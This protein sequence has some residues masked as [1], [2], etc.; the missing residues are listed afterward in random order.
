MKDFIFVTGAVEWEKLPCATDCLHTIKQ[1]V[2][3][4]NMKSH[5]KICFTLGFCKWI[6][7][8]FSALDDD[9]NLN[10]QVNFKMI[11]NIKY[12]NLETSFKMVNQ[13]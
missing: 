7:M 5:L 9:K 6:K 8:I 3:N 2:Q 10:G 1:H 12:G 11:E 13:Y 4:Q